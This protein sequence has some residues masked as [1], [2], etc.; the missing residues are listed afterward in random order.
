MFRHR[1]LLTSSP[2][3]PIIWEM[4]QWICQ[5]VVYDVIRNY[6]NN[7]VYDI[8]FRPSLAQTEDLCVTFN[9]R[10]SW[11]ISHALP[12][13]GVSAKSSMYWRLVRKIASR[14]R[15][16]IS[17]KFRSFVDIANAL[18]GDFTNSRKASE[19]HKFASTERNRPTPHKPSIAARWSF[20]NKYFGLKS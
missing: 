13:F 7:L 10:K 1:H 20:I 8:H 15:I 18:A 19:F 3:D 14:M 5:C 11:L 9:N 4:N 16:L 17:V 6:V 2:S 12:S